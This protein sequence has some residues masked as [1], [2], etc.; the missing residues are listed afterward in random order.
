[1]RMIVDLSEIVESGKRPSVMS[2]SIA[3]SLLVFTILLFVHTGC[4]NQSITNDVNGQ[5]QSAELNVNKQL[6]NEP[7]A[8]K[9]E[10]E[11]L[12][13]Q[14][15]DCYETQ[16]G[17]ET[18]FNVFS[19]LLNDGKIDLDD[20]NETYYKICDLYSYKPCATNDSKN[21][22]NQFLERKKSKDRLG[23][24]NN[25]CLL[26]SFRVNEHYQDAPEECYNYNEL[27]KRI[28]GDETTCEEFRYE[29]GSDKWYCLITDEE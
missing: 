28:G 27:C 13:A 8:Q 2:W 17:C 22:M 21:I 14:L 16:G 15:I 1:M 18:S 29:L 9:S 23:N 12:N 19:E 26:V 6:L 4:N 11:S 24:T 25:F 20:Y 5:K 10:L 3:I 7:T